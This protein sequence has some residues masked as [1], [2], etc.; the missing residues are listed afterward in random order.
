MFEKSGSGYSSSSSA[1]EVSHGIDNTV[2]DA[3]VIAR[4]VKR[5]LKESSSERVSVSS[6]VI[7]TNSP[8]KISQPEKGKVTH[9][10]KHDLPHTRET[11]FLGKQATKISA[12]TSSEAVIVSSC[13][14]SFDAI[15]HEKDL[16][17]FKGGVQG[18]ETI[19]P[20]KNYSSIVAY[21][22]RV[23]Q[24]GKIAQEEFNKTKEELKEAKDYLKEEKEKMDFTLEYLDDLQADLENSKKKF[25][26]E[27][28]YYAEVEKKKNAKVE[29]LEK[30]VKFLLDRLIDAK[31]QMEVHN[32]EI[33]KLKIDCATKYLEG[34]DVALKQVR[35]LHPNI[36]VS[37]VDSLKFVEDGKLVLM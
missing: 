37:E 19:S 26:D 4:G 25:K 9:K 33:Y 31:K 27:L 17:S 20:E 30:E 12:G 8:I 36:D 21:G 23:S 35:F 24:L 32:E 1:K 29:S 11:K 7:V 15:C 34:F 22:L 10:V 3:I 14:K 5:K 2:L 13:E 28:S 18:F 6:D 16:P